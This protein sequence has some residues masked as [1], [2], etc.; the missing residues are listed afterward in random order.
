M[1]GCAVSYMAQPP[2]ALLLGPGQAEA[3][4][5]APLTALSLYYKRLSSW[6]AAVKI[7]GVPDVQVRQRLVTLFL[8]SS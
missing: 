7:Q 2:Q 4:T 6:L 8:K 5:L 1:H 3:T